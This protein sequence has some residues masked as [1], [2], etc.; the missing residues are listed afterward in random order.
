LASANPTV[1]LSTLALLNARL[2]RA[3]VVAFGFARRDV[4]ACQLW[5]MQAQVG[6]DISLDLWIQSIRKLSNFVGHRPDP[7]FGKELATTAFGF[8]LAA[9]LLSYVLTT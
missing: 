4:E 3:P 2:Q 1:K 6:S 9:F 5:V 7:A 8:Q